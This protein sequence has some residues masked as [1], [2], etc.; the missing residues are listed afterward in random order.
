MTNM[1]L[2]SIKFDNFYQVRVDKSEVEN[3]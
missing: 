2:I 1:W 3:K